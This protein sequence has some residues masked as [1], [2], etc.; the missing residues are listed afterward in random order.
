M[1]V[2]LPGNVITAYTW[3]RPYRGFLASGDKKKKEGGSKVV[4]KK[5]NKDGDVPREFIGN[6]CVKVV[7]MR[8]LWAVIRREEGRIPSGSFASLLK[9]KDATNKVHFRTLVNDE[10]IESIDC[11]LPRDAAAKIKGRI[12]RNDDGV[13]LFK[14]ATKSGRDQVIEKGPWLIR[15]SPIILSKWSPSVS[16]KRVEVAK[17]FVLCGNQGVG[18]SL[19]ELLI[20]ID[21][22]AGLKKE[23]TMAIPVDEGDGHIKETVRVEYEWKPPHCVDCKSFGHDTL[24]CPKRV[25]EEVPKH[26]ARVA[27]TT[28]MEE[29]DDGFTEV[30]SR[31]KKKGADFNGIRLN[32]PKS[33]V[34]WQQKKGGDAKGGSKS[35]S[36]CVST[37]DDGNRV[38]NPGL[39]TAN[40][41]DV[42][43]VDGDTIGDSVS[44]P[45][46]S[47]HVDPVLDEKKKGAD[48]PSSSNSGSGNGLKGKNVRSPSKWD[49]REIINEDD[50]TDDEAVFTALGGSLGGGN[51]LEEDD[52]D[53]YDGYADQ[54]IGLD[55]ALK[56][57]R[58]FKLN[59]SDIYTTRI[60]MKNP[61]P[62]NEPNEAIPEENPVIPDPNQVVDVHDPNEMVDIP[63]DVDLVDYDGDDEE[64]PEEDPEEDPEE[65]PEPNNGLVNQFAPH[66][67]P[68]QPGVMIGWLEENDGVNEGVNNED[69][70]DE[71][72]EI[73]LDDDA[74]L[75][76]PYEVEGDK[77]LPHGGVSSNSKPPNAEPPNAESSDSVSSDSESEEKEADV[78]PEDTFGTITQRPYVVRDFSRGVFEA[79][80]A[81]SRVTEAELGT[82]QTEIA[83]LKSK[84]KIGEKEREI[85]N[86]DLG[87][88]KHVL[89]GVL[90]RLKVLESR[91]NATSKKKLVEAE[92]KLELARMEHDMV[93]RR[94]HASYGWNK[95]FYMEMVRIRA[96]PKPPSDDEGTERPRKKSNKSYF[97]GTEGPSEPR[98]PPSDSW[99]TLNLLNHSFPIDLMVIELGGFDIIIGM[100]WLS[101]YDATILCGEK[102]Y[103]EKG[104]ELFLA[105]VTEQEPKEKRLE[106]VP[107]IRDFP[108]VFPEDLPGLPPPRQVKFRIDLILGAAPVARAP[109]RLAP[110]ELKELSEQ[111]R[112]LTE[113]DFIRPRSSVDSKINLWSGYHQLLF[114]DLMNRVCKPYLD[115]FVIV[116]IDDILIYSKNK[117]EYYE[118]LKTILNLLRSEKLYAKFSKCDF[119]LDSVQFLGHVI[120]SSGI[121]IDPAKIEAIRNWP[122]PTTPTEVRQ[123]LGLAGYYQSAPILSLPDRSEDFVVYCD[124][125]LK[126]FGA[127]LMQREKV[128]AYASRQLRKNEEN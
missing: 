92:M 71:D 37:N 25:R 18:I 49:N 2:K 123:F 4:C 117:E 62:L 115:K 108:E 77:T 106:D 43:N 56:E 6:P 14:F 80:R 84:N 61:N 98:G 20:E 31:K 63:D 48:V 68:H 82:C 52:F 29:N 75:I 64:N 21:A 72:V 51:E 102:K 17:V 81:R 128:I 28:V 120:D 53:F 91:E 60:V 65:E 39:E 5:E 16:L 101:R 19:L 57:Y 93:E 23:V 10:R 11:V 109:Y 122:A 41:F 107:V 74:E 78:A 110:S 116:F 113:K 7:I 55:D 22:A 67:D 54:V 89:G 94:L 69:I 38:S 86:Y 50:T 33:T 40:P 58:D 59:M 27:N 12:T 119:W 100:D 88:V 85:P 24:L 127:V 1:N 66:V 118:H 15:K 104:G 87:N 46:V 103:I 34:M 45:K 114:M 42:L 73:E 70:E 36:P 95:R 3:N 47:T 96:V 30:K 76:F 90:E 44:Q 79:S 126:G 105:Q 8:R 99:C 125:S 121:H 35:A 26:S 97:D 13:Y 124:A 83:L 32:K 9:P 111:L 112:E